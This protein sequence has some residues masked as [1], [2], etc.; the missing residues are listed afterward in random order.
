MGV[1]LEY[2]YIF[3]MSP[4]GLVSST[5]DIPEFL[6][7]IHEV[8]L[9][10]DIIAIDTVVSVVA[11]QLYIKHCNHICNALMY[12]LPYPFLDCLSFHLQ[13]L[14]AGSMPVHRLLPISL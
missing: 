9:Q 8:F 6:S 4:V 13:L 3:S 10:A 1:S 2:S 12:M 7:D 11:S 5:F 14:L